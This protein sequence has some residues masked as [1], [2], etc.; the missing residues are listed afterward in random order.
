MNNQLL[1][2]ILFGI[3]FV[4]LDV[5]FF[6]HLSIFSS[7]AD[8]LLCYLL[9]IIQKYERVPI[10]IM[11]AS[12]ALLQDAFFDFW[13]IMMFSKTL[14]IFLVYTFVRRRSEAQLLLWQIFLII[15]MSAFIHN[16]ILFVLSSF[17]I[18][19]ATSYSP[20]AIIIGNTLYTALIGLLI[21][22]FK[23]R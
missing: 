10:L 22:I 12:F 21:Y 18:A 2:H 20:F 3:F 14:T 16:I 7:T 19:F 11:T 23:N 4:L 9:W 1:R 5:L 8:P 15:F 6:Q 17:F 13:G